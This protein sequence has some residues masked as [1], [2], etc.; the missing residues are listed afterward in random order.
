M[1]TRVRTNSGP[2]RSG[3]Q[4][5]AM[6]RRQQGVG[7]KPRVNTRD[8]VTKSKVNV[9]CYVKHQSRQAKDSSSNNTTNSGG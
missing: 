7:S 5:V 3:E 6:E 4:R 2:T 9:N 1:V 8:G